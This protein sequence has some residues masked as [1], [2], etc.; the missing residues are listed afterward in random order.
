[1][2]NPASVWK[3]LADKETA[4]LRVLG[5][6][7]SKLI[8]EK[9]RLEARLVDVDNYIAEYSSKLQAQSEFDFGIKQVYDRMNMISQLLSAKRDLEGFDRQCENAISAVTEKIVVHQNEILKYRKVS[10]NIERKTELEEKSIENKDL[11]S[12]GLR[13][14]L[15]KSS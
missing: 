5:E 15:A 9:S 4:S 10:D 14:Y 6:S 13:S 12:I 1:M 3:T 11:D 7:K 2:M 8:E